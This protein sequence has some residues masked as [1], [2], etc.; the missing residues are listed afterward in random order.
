MT[1]RITSAPLRPFD[2]AQD[3]LCARHSDSFGCGHGALD[4]SGNPKD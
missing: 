4:L 2:M 1:I 3:M